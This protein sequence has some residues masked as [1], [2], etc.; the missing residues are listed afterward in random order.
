M[1]W[2]ADLYGHAPELIKGVGAAFEGITVEAFEAAV[3]DFF[4][5]ARHPSLGVPYTEATYRPMRELIAWLEAERVH[6]S[7]SARPAAAT[8]CARSPGSSTASRGSE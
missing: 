7:T 1:A 6:A 5:T 3:R 8:S 2:L 4:E